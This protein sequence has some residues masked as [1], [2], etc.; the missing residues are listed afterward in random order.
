MRTVT[1][2]FVLNLAAADLLFA[3]TI[4]AVAYTRIVSSWKLGDFACRFMSYVQVIN[5][6]T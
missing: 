1:N 6:Q 3:F 4:P 2:S 5:L